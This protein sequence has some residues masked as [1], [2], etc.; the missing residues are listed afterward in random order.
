MAQGNT[1]LSNS[2]LY[3]TLTEV[4]RRAHV[5]LL[6]GGRSVG[7]SGQTRN[8]LSC[9][10]RQNLPARW[11]TPGWTPFHFDNF[12]LRHFGLAGRRA[13]PFGRRVPGLHVGLR[14]LVTVEC[15]NVTQLCDPRGRWE[16]TAQALSPGA[17][18]GLAVGVRGFDELAHTRLLH[19][20]GVEF[21]DGKPVPLRDQLVFNFSVF[22]E[23]AWNAIMDRFRLDD[24]MADPRLD[25]SDVKHQQM[26]AR[27]QFHVAAAAA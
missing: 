5:A 17:G 9:H 26:V 25:L 24:I 12:A 2:A 7:F 16:Y 15:P 13:R 11:S 21:L 22:D 8:T 23:V 19:A 20:G 4:F 10:V 27:L 18:I 6:A 3:P 1:R 14:L